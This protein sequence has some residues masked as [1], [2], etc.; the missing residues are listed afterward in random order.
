M[1]R[2][3]ECVDSLNGKCEKRE[4]AMIV[5]RFQKNEITL[6]KMRRLLVE[7]ATGDYQKVM[8]GKVKCSLDQLELSSSQLDICM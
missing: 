7:L 3:I 8:Y 2:L 6:T 5:P 4:K 1:G